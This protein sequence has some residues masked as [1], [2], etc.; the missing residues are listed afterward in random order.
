MAMRILHVLPTL[1]VGGAETLVSNYLIKLKNT[2]HDVAVLAYIFSDTEIY[3][4][5]KKNDIRV[6]SI[7]LKHNEII[8]E[9]FSVISRKLIGEWKYWKIIQ[10]FKPDVIHFHLKMVPRQKDINKYKGIR[11][12]YTYHSDI[13]RYIRDYGEKW[14][15]NIQA[16]S[17]SNQITSFALS[18]KMLIQVKKLISDKGLYYLPN[19]IDIISA[20]EKKY[21]K[22][23]FLK[24]LGKD[25]SNCIVAHVGRLEEVKNHKKSID[26]LNVLIKSRQDALLLIIGTGNDEHYKE[27]LISYSK[28]LGVSE[29]VLFLGFRNDVDEIL[30]ICDYALLPS[31]FEGF[32]LTALE[33]QAHGIRC[34]VSNAC[35]NEAI[36]LDNCFRLGIEESN[37]RWSELLLGDELRKDTKDIMC[38]DNTTIISK[39]LSFYKGEVN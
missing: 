32:P 34:I 30:S 39:L 3:K 11:L 1:T 13:E 22:R 14:K 25:N 33:Y 26:I 36:C 23:L 5:L 16:L 2:G 31:Y 19:G 12:F 8:K 20:Q 9:S 21:D 29:H 35:P 15:K 38:F 6:F 4:K 10:E 37:E 24:T 27:S 17:E 7:S 28:K 18:N